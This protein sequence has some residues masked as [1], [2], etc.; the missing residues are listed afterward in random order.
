MREGERLGSSRPHQTIRELVMTDKVPSESIAG[1]IFRGLISARSGSLQ[2]RFYWQLRDKL[3]LFGDPV[4]DI[5]IGATKIRAHCSHN[6][7]LY[8][9]IYKFY[10]TALPRLL[11]Q[12]TQ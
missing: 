5:P 4:I 12:L 3:K 1:I 10:D 8:K 11:R 2:E 9:K 6:L 7:P